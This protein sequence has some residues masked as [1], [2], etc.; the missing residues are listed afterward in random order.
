MA[1]SLSLFG[2][3]VGIALLLS[4]I[5]FGILASAERSGA[6]SPRPSSQGRA[7]RRTPPPSCFRRRNSLNISAVGSPRVAPLLPPGL[8]RCV[9]RAGGLAL[10]R[11]QQ[12]R[13]NRLCSPF[14]LMTRERWLGGGNAAPAVALP[15][16]NQRNHRRFVTIAASRPAGADPRSHDCSDGVPARCSAS[17]RGRRRRGRDPRAS[18]EGS[19]SGSEHRPRRRRPPAAA[20][21]GAT[22]DA[23]SHTLGHLS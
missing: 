12:V 16:L 17:G 11:S 6:S 10:L 21:S 5:G 15:V 19:A 1:E 13:K 4:G 23:A 9:P 20:N 14:S 22:F 3:L 2:I 8:L 7:L 18:P